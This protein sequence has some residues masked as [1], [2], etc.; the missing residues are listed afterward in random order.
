M[1]IWGDIAS[2]GS[3]VWNGFTGAVTSIFSGN[4]GGGG[5]GGGGGGVFTDDSKSAPSGNS[6][7][8]SGSGG[9]GS[10]SGG[11]GGG[12]GGSTPS[13]DN[14]NE[15]VKV[16]DPEKNK[17]L[18]EVRMSEEFRDT[19][20]FTLKI[21]SI[22][23]GLHTN[24]WFFMEV[25]EDFYESNYPTIARKLGEE[26][27]GR[28]AGFQP[29]RFFVD[30]VIERGGVDGVSMEITL[31]PLA[32]NYGQYIKMQQEAE[33]ALIDAINEMNKSKG[34]SGGSAGGSVNATGVDCDA[35]DKYN[36]HHWSG[37]KSNPPKCTATGKIVRGNSSR[38]YAKDTAPYG[39]N[40]KTLVDYV[41]SQVLYQY[42]GNNPY[43]ASRCPEA[44][45]TGPRP[46]RG[47]CADYARLLKCILDVN[48]YNSIICH[49]PGHFYNAI[50]ENNGWTVCDLC[51]GLHG[52]SAYGHA[53]HG[54]IKPI[55]TWDNPV[56]GGESDS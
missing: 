42:Y 41:Q 10:G 21:P 51:A 44:M 14:T 3:N 48:G 37:H 49:I 12:S 45:W 52:K 1:S 24:S 26:K 53:N 13:T 39:G 35:N 16:N 30:K 36:S 8:S 5:F 7:S 25:P 32:P 23:K 15:N 20:S 43:G 55:G 19:M 54:D 6:K 9:G 17:K 22:L 33:K 28:Y 38:Q 46:I 4:K 11:S 29:G 18:A 2:F 56:V 27:F 31:N 47:N 40:S 34:G 50:W